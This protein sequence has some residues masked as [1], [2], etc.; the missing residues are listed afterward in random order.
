VSFS[1]AELVERCRA[2]R[3]AADFSS[4][5]SAVLAE[6]LATPDWA[7]AAFP[8]GGGTRV[9]VLHRAADLT[10]LHARCAPGF[11]YHPHDH[12]VAS[13]VGIIRGAERNVYHRRAGA[14]LEE[15]GRGVLRAGEVK[16]HPA[17]R[18]HAIATDGDETLDAFHVYAGDF[19]A[20]PRSEW[21]GDPPAE[22]PYDIANALKLLAR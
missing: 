2:A 11:R 22:R 3:A 6:A 15:I 18:I 20:V 9:T 8:D 7:C 12:G 5:L 13:V 1:T 4:Q 21:T 10:V 16:A 19:F 14:L 17:D